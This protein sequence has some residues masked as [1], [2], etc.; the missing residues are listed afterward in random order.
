MNAS[1]NNPHTHSMHDAAAGPGG[2]VPVSTGEAAPDAV[3]TAPAGAVATPVEGVWM[4]QQDNPGPMTLD[5]TQS[6]WIPSQRGAI[7]VDPGDD[8]AQHQAALASH[9]VALILVT[10]RHPDHVGGLERLR[11]LTG[12]PSRALSSDYCGEGQE[13]LTDGEIIDVPGAGLQLRVLATPGH[14]SDSIS[15]VIES[16]PEARPLGVLTADTILGRGTTIIDHPDGRLTNYLDSLEK[17]ETLGNIP[18]LPAHAGFLPSVAETARK[19]LAHRR[20]RLEQVRAAVHTLQERGE[21][22]TVS[23]VTDIVY[24]D[25]DAEVRPAAEHTVSAQLAAL[26]DGA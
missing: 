15:I 19:Y 25:V 4:V 18:A 12:A 17:L 13:P 10:H 9:E 21:E 11:D 22:A 16:T 26:E 3:D 24:A 23:N 5:G 14:T 1:E 20:E 8:D 6:Y 7:V 2:T